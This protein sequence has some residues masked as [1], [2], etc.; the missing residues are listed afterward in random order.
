MTMRALLHS[1]LVCHLPLNTTWL[2]CFLSL[3]YFF[4]H[5]TSFKKAKTT[6][7]N[8]QSWTFGVAALHTL[9]QTQRICW[10]CT[11]R[12]RTHVGG[13]KHHIDITFYSHGCHV[14][15]AVIAAVIL[16]MQIGKTWMCNATHFNGLLRHCLRRWLKL[17][18]RARGRYEDVKVN[19]SQSWLHASRT[20]SL[21]IIHK[22]GG[23]TNHVPAEHG[24][25]CFP[26]WVHWNVEISPET[27]VRPIA[28]LP[29]VLPTLLV[30]T[31]S[32]L[33]ER[34]HVSMHSEKLILY[35]YYLKTSY[36]GCFFLLCLLNSAVSIRSYFL[37]VWT[38]KEHN[39]MCFKMT[40][41]MNVT[42]RPF[43]LSNHYN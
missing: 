12:R 24:S 41:H 3:I 18:S 40:V 7:Q 13:R 1:L 14:I 26:C 35:F 8:W 43:Q 33:S 11:N 34:L 5:G 29:S 10:N 32:C 2:V 21:K 42:V 27:L 38:I 20:D 25:V 17:S 28:V 39:G 31:L 22:R 37:L 4:L 36:F 6:K 15:W 16:M 30:S 19:S 9:T 23:K